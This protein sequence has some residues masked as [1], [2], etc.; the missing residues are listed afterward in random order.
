MSKTAIEQLKELREKQLKKESE[1][2]SALDAEFLAKLISKGEYYAV[3]VASMFLTL[4][5][6]WCLGYVR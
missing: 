1:E 4:L 5:L 2:Q 3:L 6:I